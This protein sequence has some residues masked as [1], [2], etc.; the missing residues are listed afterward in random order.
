MWVDS[1]RLSLDADS[2]MSKQG[3][4]VWTY[5]HKQ[6]GDS[7]L[8]V[9]IS[10]RSIHRFCHLGSRTP[11]TVNGSKTVRVRTI[12]SGVFHRRVPW[13]VTGYAST[14]NNKWKLCV[15]TVIKTQL[16][17]C[18]QVYSLIR[19]R[20]FSTQNRAQHSANFGLK[21]RRPPIKVNLV[22]FF[23]RAEIL[24]ILK[25]RIFCGSRVREG[26]DVV[27]GMDFQHNHRK[28]NQHCLSWI[29]IDTPTV[30]T[31]TFVLDMPVLTHLQMKRRG[32]YFTRV[33][34]AIF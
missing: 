11:A 14:R 22:H 29:Q 34:S 17:F 4:F 10:F 23:C 16:A 13:Q 1:A 12:L 31:R 7:K 24:H 9:H 8:H 21:A 20:T 5:Q 25:N 33:S 15:S 6:G 19:F 30:W 27:L 26:E 28:D 32:N 3:Y 2:K 18:A